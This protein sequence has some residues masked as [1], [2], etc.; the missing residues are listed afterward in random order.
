MEH[1]PPAQ[2]RTAVIVPTQGPTV[3]GKPADETYTAKE[4]IAALGGYFAILYP[5]SAHGAMLIV[6]R[7]WGGL[8]FNHHATEIMTCA[9]GGCIVFGTALLTQHHQVE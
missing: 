9:G 2:L 3:K 8:P 5:P 4:L 6:R 7:D 1:D